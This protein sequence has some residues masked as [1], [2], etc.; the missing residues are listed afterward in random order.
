MQRIKD[1]R[2]HESLVAHVFEV[3]HLGEVGGVDGGERGADLRQP[4]R[5]DARS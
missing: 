3:T 5:G 1:F 2:F 4:S